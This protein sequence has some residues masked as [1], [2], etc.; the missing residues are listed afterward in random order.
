MKKFVTHTL[1]IMLL[2]LAFATPAMAGESKRGFYEA[3]LSGGGKLLLFVSR[4]SEISAFV[5][6][7][8]GAQAS[9]GNGTINTADGTFSFALSN[10]MTISG[11]VEH[12]NRISVTYNGQT[13]TAQREPSFGRCHGIA[14]FFSGVA[15]APTGETLTDVTFLI[16]SHG[17]IFLIANNGTSIIGGFGLADP[18]NPNGEDEHGNRGRSAIHGTFT[19]T[20]VDGTIVP[21]TFGVSNGSLT[22]TFTINGIVYTFKGNKDSLNN[23][24][25]NISTRGFVGTGQSVLIGGFI[26]TGGPKLV[27]IRA[28][29]PTLA[30]QGVSPVLAN[31]KVEL[32]QG[33]SL[34]AENDDWGTAA[35]ADDITA[36]GL[37]PTNANEAAI[38]IRLEPGAYTTIVS[39]SDGGTGI[40]LVEI[41]ES[42]KE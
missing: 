40:A 22:G 38:L 41:Y 31:P 37:A 15:T 34:L 1:G 14:G 7:T 23:H 30:D 25:A 20:L 24:L 36:S 4:N 21:G 42:D 39:G 12:T 3:D 32:F 13:L 18:K 35:N 9:L 2:V 33:Q 10:G 27:L 11:D 16:D 26:I 28:L 5:F 6:D 19:L 17:R 8:A 29:G